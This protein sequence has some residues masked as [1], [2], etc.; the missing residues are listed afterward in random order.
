[1]PNKG[2]P[3]KSG[4]VRTFIDGSVRSSISLRSASIGLGTYHPGW[5]WSL[6]A[7]AQTGKD[8]ENHIGYIISGNIMVQDSTGIE[9]EV[10]PGEA[11]E[12]GPGHDAWVIG[13]E[14][15]IALDFIPIDHDR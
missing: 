2:N 8:S 12:V 3:A 1:M 15:C 7:G 5:K 4:N 13:G 6:H 10:G 9:I 11:F 14:P